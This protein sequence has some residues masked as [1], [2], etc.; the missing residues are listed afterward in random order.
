MTNLNF[1]QATSI[2]SPFDAVVIEFEDQFIVPKSEKET[3]NFGKAL[4]PKAMRYLSCGSVSNK[5]PTSWNALD[6]SGEKGPEFY[7]RIEEILVSCSCFRVNWQDLD[8]NSQ[9]ATVSSEISMLMVNCK[10]LTSDLIKEAKC[11]TVFTMFGR[12][13]LDLS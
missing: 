2:M 7:K 8:N 10:S 11:A 4:T 9:V 1:K 6:D 13:N 5:N 3:F 12:V